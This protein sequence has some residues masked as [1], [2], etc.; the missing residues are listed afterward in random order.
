VDCPSKSHGPA[1]PHPQNP[2]TAGFVLAGAPIA[3][4]DD[5]TKSKVRK[6]LTHRH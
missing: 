2:L 5:K 3:K 6:S 1:S 4:Y